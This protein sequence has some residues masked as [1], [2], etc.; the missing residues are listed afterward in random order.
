L[1]LKYNV[2][3][4]P[5]QSV[6]FFSVLRYNFSL[7]STLAGLSL[8]LLHLIKWRDLNGRVRKYSLISQVSSKWEPFGYRLSIPPNV[9]EGWR[10]EYMANAARCWGKVMQF[11]LSEYQ[12][13]CSD[14]EAEYPAT[15]E[16][17]YEMLEDVEFAEVAKQL[18]EAV[19]AAK[20]HFH[21]NNDHQ[22]ASTRLSNLRL[23]TWFLYLKPLTPFTCN[24]EVSVDSLSP[25]LFTYANRSVCMLY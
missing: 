17:L 22:H 11:W 3:H 9:L 2:N 15:W 8:R 18:K 23:D 7:V 6:N 25:G 20:K 10:E 12:Q 19:L 5:T 1:V 14:E 13:E 16:G 21:A 4:L 24:D